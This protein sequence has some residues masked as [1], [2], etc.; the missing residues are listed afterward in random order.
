MKLV[1]KLSVSELDQLNHPEGG[2]LRVSRDYPCGVDMKGQECG[3]EVCMDHL[4]DS[5][6]PHIRARNILRNGYTLLP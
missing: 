3:C 6:S 1:S 4:N 2:S 5:T